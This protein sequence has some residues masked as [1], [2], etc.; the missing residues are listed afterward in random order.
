MRQSLPRTILRQAE[1]GSDVPLQV[2]WRSGSWTAYQVNLP[3]DGEYTLTLHMKSSQANDF[4]IYRNAL[5]AANKKLDTTLPSTNGAWQD[6]KTTVTLAAGQ[7]TLLLYNM[8]T[9]PILLNSLRF[10][11]TSGIRDVRGKKE[12]VRADGAYYDLQGRLVT[13]PTKG[14]YIMN[15]R[16]VV[17]K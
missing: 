17:M 7:H 8:G 13:H 5:G 16:K 12:D 4:R 9:S 15:G 14:I 11:T 2:E 6:V 3:S 10:D 1:S